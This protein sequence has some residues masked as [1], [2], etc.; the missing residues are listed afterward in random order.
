[1]SEFLRFI[2][3]LRGRR[4]VWLEVAYSSVIDWCITVHFV[5]ENEKKCV[6]NVQHCDME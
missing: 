2:D 3:E 4:K 5:V 6:V 1:M